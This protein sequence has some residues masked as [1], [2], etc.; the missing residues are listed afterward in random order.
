MTN[1]PNFTRAYLLAVSAL[2]AAGALFHL[3]IIAIGAKGY[4]LMGAPAGLVAL[5]GT[6]SLRPAASCVVI[7]ALLAL[8]CAYGLSAA[9]V[10]PRLP[11]RRPM[12]ALVAAVFLARGL[13]LPVVAAR[14]P[15]LLRG[16]CGRCEDVNGF[17][18]LKSGLC[19]FVGGAFALGAARRAYSPAIRQVFDP[20]ASG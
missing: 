6:G 5:V 10:G 4:A 2:M 11:A 19:L 1:L 17:V 20:T 13:V 9:D 7:A 18:L 14:A 12:L 16:L 15:E 8:G 3:A